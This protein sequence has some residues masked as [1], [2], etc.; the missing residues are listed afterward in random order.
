MRFGDGW[1]P[2][3]RHASCQ[4]QER[5]PHDEF[6]A[7]VRARASRLDVAL[8]HLDDAL[9]ERKPDA[10]PVVAVRTRVSHL[11]EQLEDM[12]QVFLR[13][14]D[15]SVAHHDRRQLVRD[16]YLHFD[17]PAIGRELGRV[18][19]QVADYLREPHRVAACTC[20]G[21]PGALT[22]MP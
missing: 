19:D 13:D 1:L 7:E 3:L 22:T 2:V 5:K 12:R 17:P 6:A 14:A 11:A 9:H 4:L 18:A 20:S 21:L 15:A 16:A 10:E 8:V